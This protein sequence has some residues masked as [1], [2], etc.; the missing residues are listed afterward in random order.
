MNTFK[1]LVTIHL[2]LNQTNVLGVV[3]TLNDFANKVCVPNKTD[4]LNLSVFSIRNK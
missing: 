2:W 4:D 3:N 1:N